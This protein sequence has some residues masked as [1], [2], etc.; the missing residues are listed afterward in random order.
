MPNMRHSAAAARRGYRE[1]HRPRRELPALGYFY[2]DE[3]P[4]RRSATNRLLRS[5]NIQ[6]PIYF[7]IFELRDIAG[8]AF[9]CPAKTLRDA[10]V[11]HPAPPNRVGESTDVR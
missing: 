8:T 10:S 4:L 7:S 2:L 11:L 5:R 3:E 1:L 6:C 9:P